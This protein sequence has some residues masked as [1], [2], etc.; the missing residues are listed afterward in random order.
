VSAGPPEELIKRLVLPS[1]RTF[2]VYVPGSM[3]IVSPEPALFTAA[4]I[5]FVLLAWI[6][7]AAPT[8]ELSVSMRV[9]NIKILILCI[10]IPPYNR[11]NFSEILPI[12]D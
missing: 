6:T 3:R 1:M 9:A 5:E 10:L 11:R 12:I 2:S 4:C 8:Q 7:A